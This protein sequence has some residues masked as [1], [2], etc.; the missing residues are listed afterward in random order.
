M[1]GTTK[2]AGPEYTANKPTIRH[3]LEKDKLI[4]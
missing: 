1:N 2:R 3:E 4:D